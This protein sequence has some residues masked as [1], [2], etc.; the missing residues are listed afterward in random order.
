MASFFQVLPTLRG[1]VASSAST[2]GLLIRCACGAKPV[3]STLAR[4]VPPG[5]DAVQRRGNFTVT[6]ERLEEFLN[7]EIKYLAQREVNPVKLEQIVYV[8]HPAEVAKLVHAEIP[9]RFAQRMLHI[10]SIAEWEEV[11]M[12]KQVHAVFEQSF[13]ELRLADESDLESF[14]EVIRRLRKRHKPVVPMISQAIRQMYEE[15]ILGEKALNT[16]VDSFMGSRISTEMLTSHFMACIEAGQSE[17]PGQMTSWWG[18]I[19]QA[20]SSPN[21]IVDTGC[22]PA[23]VCQ[24]VAESVQ[25]TFSASS[26]PTA[27]IQIEVNRIPDH[28][29][30]EFSYVTKYLYFVVEE[31]LTNAVRAV[32]ENAT[33]AE[34]LQESIIKVV[35]CADEKNVAIRIADTGGGIPFEHTESV[36]SYVFSTSE[37]PPHQPLGS[38]KNPE[39]AKISSSPLAGWGMGLPLSRLYV[40]YLGG[41]LELKNMPGIGVDTYLFLNRIDLTDANLD[42]LFSDD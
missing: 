20:P 15:A 31:L 2:S 24:E 21:G 3:H 8:T 14:T 29:E 4:G 32:A 28:T 39:K 17:H 9:P 5:L 37:R 26:Y 22:D 41:S 25:A 34:E 38:L 27:K 12:L 33:S 23:W 35:V 7:A 16:W 36:W 10:E 19:L 11:P 30:I 13:R 40:R 6:N 18:P 1:A 42:S